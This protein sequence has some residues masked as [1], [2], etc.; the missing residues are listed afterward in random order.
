M[1]QH[2]LCLLR[3]LA[4]LRFYVLLIQW[5]ELFLLVYDFFVCHMLLISERL[6]V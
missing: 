5:P 2:I 1:V 3:Q 6:A 4:L